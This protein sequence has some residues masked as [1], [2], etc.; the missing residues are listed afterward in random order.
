MHQSFLEYVLDDLE[1]KKIAFEEC[2]FVLP[3]K[4]SGTFLKKYLSEKLSRNIFA[5]PILSIE[6]F[7]EDI[8]G[9]SRT[10]SIELLLVLFK[11]YQHADLE[12]HDDFDSFLKWGQTLLQDFNEIDRYL[13][14]ADDI[15]NYLS[16]IKD[17]THWS[18]KKEKTALIQ[19]YLQLWTNLE[20]FY[21]RF[22]NA[23]LQEKKGYQGLIYKT[24][25]ENLPSY[26]EKNK[27]QHIV[28]IGFNA[29]NTAES[30]IIQ[31]FLE[32]SDCSAYWDI[33][34]YFLDDPLHDAGLFI[35]DYKKNWH[36]YQRN[37][38]PGIHSSF[39]NPKNI[40]VTGVPKNISQ[41]KYVGSLLEQ[42][43]PEASQKLHNTAVVLADESLLDPILKAV[44][45]DIGE[46]NITMGLPLNKTIL[47]SFF[48]SFLD[49]HIA[50]SNKGWFYNDVL[51]FLANPY[52]Q[53]ISSVPNFSF[54]ATLS[55]E[56]KK[57]NWI[58]LNQSLLFKQ[59]LPEHHLQLIFPENALIPS[60]WISHCLELIQNLKEHFQKTGNNLELE[61]L[62]RF[63][64]LFNQ[65]NTHV[66]YEDFITN[67]KSLKSFFTQLAS[68]ETLDFIGEP[69]TGLQIMGMLES[70]N[71]DF[72]TVILTSINEGILPAGKSNSSFIPFD[73]KREYGLPTYKEKDAIYTYHFYRLIQRAKNVHIIYNTEP[74]VLEGG[75]KSRLISQL[76][77]DEN[78]SP[79]I[80]HEIASPKVRISPTEPVQISKTPLLL[81]ELDSLAKKGYSPTSLTNY[82]RNPIDFYKK[83]ILKINEHDEVEESIAANT[84]GTI[85]HDSLEQLYTP[86]LGMFL[87]ETSLSEAISI[88][89]SVVEQH[90]ERL[91]PGVSI[92]KG[93]FLLVYNVIVKYL[94][95][96]IE[97]EKKL[98]KKHQIRILG[99][100]QKL[101][102]EFNIPDLDFPIVLKGTLDRIDEFDGVVRVVDYKTGKVEPK[103]VKVIDWDDL[104]SDYEKSKAFQLLCYA[105]L[106]NQCN[107]SHTI[108]AG[109]YSFKNLRQG[110]LSFNSGNPLINQET[111]NTFKTYLEK[112]IL[113]IYNPQIPFLEKQV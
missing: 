101:E 11:T 102:T 57:N 63:Y 3:S 21:N 25:V 68:T 54:L 92:K 15:L 103:N 112:L 79:F 59:S 70:R 8:A 108:Q 113:E 97:L 74:D 5:P 66:A 91:L 19:N 38:F 61:Y 43:T 69:L 67:L 14:P 47:Y 37:E 30:K 31:H 72:E 50:K 41:A 104:I 12:N 94:K 86:M 23:L 80:S 2:T 33:D 98:L 111:L 46:A 60:Q 20:F 105:Y 35:R 107:D 53:H 1:Q 83:S 88:L 34:S 51:T 58:Y 6:E 56:I 95:N 9:L 62:Y 49:L 78:I 16:V 75:E 39:L 73:V 64:T 17:V 24:A 55:R 44:P 28:F 65:L 32:T 96:F 100:E 99:L 109:I 89:P 29:L 77:T 7:I 40:T 90:F 82:V 52:S 10:S 76:L 110:F 42:I 13:I 85:V 22:T 48:L 26:S 4:R 27:V 106:Y 45:S 93:R 84:F 81:R 87:T 18:L 36:Y 71:L